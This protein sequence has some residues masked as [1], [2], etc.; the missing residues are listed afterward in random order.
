MK[1]LLTLLLF[2]TSIFAQQ[3]VDSLFIAKDSID[4]VV[5]AVNEVTQPVTG[6]GD[7]A[8]SSSNQQQIVLNHK[9]HGIMPLS[10]LS[11]GLRNTIVMVADIA[12]R[13]SKLNPHL[14]AK[15]ALESYGIVMIDE[16]DM[17]LHP[18]WQQKILGALRRAF[19]KIQF[20]V[21]THSPQILTTV[22]KESIRI[23]TS[24]RA[25]EPSVHTLGE[26]SRVTLEDVMHVPSRPKDEYSDLLT[27]YL[28]KI[29]RG[30]IDSTEVLQMRADLEGHYGVDHS[31]LQLADTRINYW[32]AVNHK[33]V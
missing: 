33:D 7:I 18:E 27:Q 8:Y 1:K 22:P 28:K 15:A 26:E 25:V 30:D 20:I 23:I 21:T 16:V 32:R 14:G 19:P 2:T 3:P 13:C 6:W 4:V 31:Q 24:D 17:F 9:E 12:F 5:G 29:N 10:M 11:D